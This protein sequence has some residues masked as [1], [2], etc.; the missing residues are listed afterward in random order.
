MHMTTSPVNN[1][2]WVFMG[3]GATHP[4][5]VFATKER[6]D[7]WIRQW[8]VTGTL[9]AYPLDQSVYDWAIAGR[10]FHPTH[11]SHTE[12]TFVQR[13]SSAYAEHYHYDRGAEAGSE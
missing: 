12:P 8:K 3:E 4:C 1:Q 9:T 13:F 11:P 10:H 2:V 5:A 6:A 7:E